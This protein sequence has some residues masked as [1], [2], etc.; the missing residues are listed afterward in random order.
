MKN[1][2]AGL[3][4]ASEKIIR[5]KSINQINLIGDPGCDGLG[6]GIMSIFAR[7]LTASE[8]DFSL[9][10]GDMVP[11][12]SKQIYENV[13]TF[14]NS[15]AVHPVFTLKG[16][17]DTKYFNEYF[18]SPNY[19][20]AAENLLVLVLDNAG[21]VFTP[22]A[23]D[24]CRNTLDNNPRENIIFAFH[25][26]PPNPIAANSINPPEWESFREIY[27]PHLENIRY[28]ISGHVH[29]LVESSID[30]IPILI[31]GGGGA[32]IEPLGS[33]EVN[34]YIRHHIIRLST[35]DTGTFSHKYI[36]LD[37]SNYEKE[38]SD[39]VLKKKVESALQNEIFAHF[40]YRLMA[41]NADEQGWSSLSMLFTA[42][43]DSEFYHASN[44]FSIL[45]REQ[46]LPADLTES[47]KN[48]SFEVETMYKEYASYAKDHG[49]SLAQY[50]FSDALNAEKVH[51]ELLTKAKDA[52][53]HG[54][55]IPPSSYFTCS[56]CGYTFE[57][58]ESPNRCPVCGAP[59][60]KILPVD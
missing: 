17:H 33:E 29:S 8:A 24:F 48:E 51:R 32:R 30:N 6:A 44:H 22:E 10:I 11:H 7:A 40:K 38:T 1:K 35:D 39:P 57:T 47:I 12:G 56:S 26:P 14:I 18:G 19:G 5:T 59:G 27:L 36:F 23:L 20:I 50:T 58:A 60:D 21:R 41:R 52:V 55:D 4:T 9:I 28:F 46:S 2:P 25:Y 45:N 15:A 3:N 42:L 37:D 13:V 49:H 43:S 54:R 31:T 16:N 34:G 53:D